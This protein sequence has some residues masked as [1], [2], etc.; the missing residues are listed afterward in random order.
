MQFSSAHTMCGVTGI[1]H[2]DGNSVDRAVL[3]LM[4]STLR[5]RSPDDE[6]YLLIDVS[7]GT[8]EPRHGDDTVAEVG[9]QIPHRKSVHTDNTDPNKL[10]E[11][12]AFAKPVVVSNCA[13]LEKR[14]K[15]MQCG[16]VFTSDNARELAE[17]VLRLYRDP[18]QAKRF[19]E[20]GYRA[21]QDR[22]NW[23]VTV[24]SLLDLYA[25]LQR[26]R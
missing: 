11:Y 5:H 12:L 20:N 23:E 3:Q 21:V 9:S 10:Y 13:A 25:S 26:R 18:Q 24:T 1:I 4:T 19:G 17:C 22:Y 15:E 7:S 6:G 16:L 8:A 14:V 2:T